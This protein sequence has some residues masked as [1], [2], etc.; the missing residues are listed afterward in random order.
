MG[1]GMSAR[2]TITMMESNSDEEVKVEDTNA[3]DIKEDV[4]ED[5]D[6]S[7]LP[8]DISFDAKERMADEAVDMS[9]VDIAM[10][11][12]NGIATDADGINLS[13]DFDTWVM[14]MQRMLVAKDHE[15]H[16]LRQELDKA[17]QQLHI[18]RP[19]PPR[20]LDIEVPPATKESKDRVGAYTKTPGADAALTTDAAT[21]RVR[22]PR[23]SSFRKK[24]ERQRI[25][26]EII[27]D[28]YGDKGTYTGMILVSTRMPHGTGRMVYE[29]DERVYDGQWCC[30]RWHGFGRAD[31]A[32]GD[33]YEGDY[34]MDQREGYGK[35]SWQDGRAYD[36]Q[37]SEDRRNGEGVFVWPDGSIY[38]SS[39]QASRMALQS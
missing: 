25:D 33:W 1:S 9:N 21:P 39:S 10:D 19:P 22:N 13:V 16:F 36:G 3:V 4:D 18:L 15:I 7:P 20:K 34:N 17:N 29:G 2:T 31:F 27:L 23:R 35:Y 30:G 37:F 12:H 38:V 14:H 24:E 5:T 11:D 28:P 8:F 6:L 32:N 26:H